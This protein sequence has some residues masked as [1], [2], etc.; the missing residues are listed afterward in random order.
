MAGRASLAFLGQDDLA[1][2]GDPEDTYF[3]QIHIGK[4]SFISKVHNISLDVKLQESDDLTIEIPKAGDL[5]TKLYLKLQLSS[6]VV[7][8]TYLID[9]VEIQCDGIVIE[10]LYGEYIELINEL[11][12]PQSKKRLLTAM[13][14]SNYVDEA[15]TSSSEPY[16]LHLNFTC[17]RHGIPLCALGKSVISLRVVLRSQKNPAY[18][19]LLLDTSLHPEYTYISEWEKRELM[20]KPLIYLIEQVQQV[21]HNFPLDTNPSTRIYPNLRGPVKEIILVVQKATDEGFKFSLGAKEP[22]KSLNLNLSGID[23]IQAE[24]ASGLYLRVIQPLEH[25]TSV[26]IRNV[27]CYSFCLDPEDPNPTGSLNM[28]RIQSQ[29]LDLTFNLPEPPLPG[30]IQPMDVGQVRLYS[31]SYNFFKVEGGR[32][33]VLYSYS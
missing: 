4:T 26:P 32:G 12:T 25:H 19:G 33:N 18:S 2:S 24:V 21:K 28:S 29:I 5:I 7:V 10:R 31:V 23:A 27:Y 30:L 15:V 20:T 14:G 22:L 11:T 13:L 3:K 8:A 16:I 17:L 6:N 1:L 9:F